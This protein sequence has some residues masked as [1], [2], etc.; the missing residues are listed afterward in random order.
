MD[1]SSANPQAHGIDP[2]VYERRWRILGV[3]CLSLVLIVAANSAL[4]VA[5][6]TLVRDLEA[7]ATQLQWIVDAYALVFAGLLLPMGAIGDR[8]GRRRLLQGGLLVFAIGTLVAT[9]AGDATQVIIARAVMGVGGAMVMPGTLS[10]LAATFPPAERGRAIAIWAGFSGA[11]GAI[12]PVLSGALLG[13]FWWGSVFLINLP[14]I[15]LALGAGMVWLPESRE[16][17]RRPLDPT[18]SAL[19]VLALGGLLFGI[20]EGPERGWTHGLTLTGFAVGLAAAVAFVWWERRSEHPMLDISWFAERRFTVGTTTITLAFFAAFGV[21]FLATQ[22]FQFVLGYSALTAAFGGL[23]IAAALVVV[24]PRSAGLVERAGHRVVVAGGLGLLAVGLGW[25]AAVTTPDTAYWLI[26]PGLV[27]F[28]SGMALTVAPSTGL[29][30]SALPI[31]RAGVGSAVNDTVREL[32]GALGVAVLGSIVAG[33][34]KA[35]LDV[36]ALPE[37]L[38]EVA[39]ESVGAALQ[40]A[41]QSPAGEAFAAAARGAFTDAFTLAMGVAAAVALL[42]SA[43]VL[44]FGIGRADA[45]A[46]APAAAHG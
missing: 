43:M 18:G 8:L 33:S 10:L 1:T 12:G 25:L 9:V 32:G 36:S 13:Q 23:P 5:L 38:G 11:G 45:A 37:G 7:T 15:A 46:P 17:V 26:L 41:A 29:I 31:D 21:F 44:R 27:A 42:A 14:I 19:S 40:V 24:A 28:G 39:R 34:Y 2:A 20:I 6:P 4:N 3:L 22:Y 16:V 30:I 35:A